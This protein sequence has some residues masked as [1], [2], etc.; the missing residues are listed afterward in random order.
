MKKKEVITRADFLSLTLRSLLYLSG[1]L[2]AIGLLRF[3]GFSPPE[4]KPKV[5]NL[6]NAADIP[7]GT[8]KLFPE[9]RVFLI[10]SGQEW[11]ALSL[12]CPH[13]G[14]VVR[15]ELDGGFQCPCHGSAFD[16]EGNRIK[17][18]AGR[19][20]DPLKVEN[21]GQGQIIVTA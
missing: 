16:A 1:T 6:G 10:H 11:R 15:Q 17:G 3:F 13:L 4:S 8:R 20:L 12:V 21:D 9:Q 2:L 5:L 19:G 14:C 18:P 7:P